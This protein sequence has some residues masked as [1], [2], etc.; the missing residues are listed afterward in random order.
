MSQTYGSTFS[1]GASVEGVCFEFALVEAAFFKLI[2]ASLL[3]LHLSTSSASWM[4][5]SATTSRLAHR[6]SYIE[7]ERRGAKDLCITLYGGP[8]N[9]SCD[10]RMGN[11]LPDCKN[12]SG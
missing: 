11:Y 1:E 12:I 7:D 8:G 3:K 10:C 6:A 4:P 9:R 5:S 2:D